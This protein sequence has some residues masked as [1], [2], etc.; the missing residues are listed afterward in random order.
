MKRN[1]IKALASL[2]LVELK[3]KGT[4]LRLAF[5]KARM[6]HRVGKLKNVRILSNLRHDMARVATISKGK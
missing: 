1:D 2:S 3:Q 4:E 5:A 6:D